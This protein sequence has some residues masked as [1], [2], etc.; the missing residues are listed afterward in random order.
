MSPEKDFHNE[1]MKSAG[2]FLDAAEYAI[3]SDQTRLAI[4][5]FCTAFEI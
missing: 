5:Q 3:E 1:Y 2:F 4:H